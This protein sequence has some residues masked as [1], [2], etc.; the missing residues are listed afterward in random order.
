MVLPGKTRQGLP[1]HKFRSPRPNS[2][3]HL[4]TASLRGFIQDTPQEKS[5]PMHPETPRASSDE[6]LL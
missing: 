1:F 2:I 6:K 4:V 5:L 3:A